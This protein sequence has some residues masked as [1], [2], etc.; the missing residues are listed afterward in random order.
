MPN[1][2]FRFKQFTIQ[3]DR[4]AMKV[5]TD[6]CIL[7]AWTALRING[8]TNN[9]DNGMKNLLEYKVKNILDIGTGTALL[10][11][12]LAQKTDARIDT[13][14]C[15]PE[16]CLQAGENIKSS[17]WSN[18]IQLLEGDARDYFFPSVYDFI[19]SNPPFFDSDLRSP[20]QKKNMAKH[21]ESLTLEKLIGLIQSNLQPDGA[22]SILLPFHR[23]EYFKKL[24]G[25]NGFFLQ[26]EL[27]VKQTP[28]HSPFRSILLFS[29]MKSQKIILEELT[30]KKADGKYSG[31]FKSL[32]EDY[33]G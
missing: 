5:C 29:S 15:D 24:A 4:C 33:Y 25:E 10:P 1:S 32:M 20:E 2:F 22:F 28:S 14:E 19:I 21:N 17:P 7:G 27:A 6:S 23:N 16:T 30:I 26:E 8:V 3:Q 31:E 18:R 9:L 13:V 12:M 11:L